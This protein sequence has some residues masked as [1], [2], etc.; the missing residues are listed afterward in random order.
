MF[1]RDTELY[2]SGS[3]SRLNV[4]QK[5]LVLASELVQFGVRFLK[6]VDACVIH[7]FS[8]WI[9]ELNVF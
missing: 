4:F 8:F 5:L 2:I 7:L 6:I 1:L 9:I 3:G